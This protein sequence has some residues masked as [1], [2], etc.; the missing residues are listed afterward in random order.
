MYEEADIL[1]HVSALPTSIAVWNR[2]L[3]QYKWADAAPQCMLNSH[4]TTLLHCLSTA[5]PA[6]W[7]CRQFAYGMLSHHRDLSFGGYDC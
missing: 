5:E 2:Q 3:S 7:T 6:A 4:H 1:L